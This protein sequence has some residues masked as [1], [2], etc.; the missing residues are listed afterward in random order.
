V[1]TSASDRH[2]RS[3]AHEAP[4]WSLR[5]VARGCRRAAL[6]GLAHFRRTSQ[7]HA[8]STRSPLAACGESA[9]SPKPSP[10]PQGKEPSRRCIPRNLPQAT[11]TPPCGSGG[12]CRQHDFRHRLLGPP[13]TRRGWHGRASCPA[14]LRWSTPRWARRSPFGPRGGAAA[15]PSAPN[16]RCSIARGPPSSLAMMR[17]SVAV[18]VS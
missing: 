12:G 16:L 9:A 11:A 13:R 2:A 7:P 5:L 10:L 14:A 17:S 15:T 6:R 3:V 4:D 1:R 18:P 8:E